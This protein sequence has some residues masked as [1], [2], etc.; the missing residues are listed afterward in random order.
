[1]TDTDKG[2]VHDGKEVA[3]GTDPLNPADDVEKVKEVIQE[4]KIVLDL[5]PILFDFDSYKLTNTAVTSLNNYIDML[6]KHENIT[7]ELRGYTD[8][9][10][11]DSYNMKL[12]ENRANAVMDYLVKNGIAKE[13]LTISYFGETKPVAPNETKEGR[14]L[15][16]RVELQQLDK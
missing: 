11:A 7:V 2:T 12:S 15:N 9:I 10:G 3:R 4:E 6:K 8:N 1:M 16:R 13:R 5:E 14:K